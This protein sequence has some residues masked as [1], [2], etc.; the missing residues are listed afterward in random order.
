MES[1]KLKLLHWGEKQGLF[2]D[3][4]CIYVSR[5]VM[6]FSNCPLNMF[7]MLPLS[8]PP[9]SK[10]YKIIACCSPCRCCHQP[11]RPRDGRS[12]PQGDASACR[13][14]A[15]ATNS[16]AVIRVPLAT[17]AFSMP[18]AFARNSATLFHVARTSLKNF[19]SSLCVSWAF[20]CSFYCS[21]K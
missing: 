7:K 21:N 12:A 4:K 19:L 2:Q 17:A 8:L 3:I 14:P 13:N 15:L 20:L 18:I 10:R 1:I 16:L 11:C 6:V 9:A 5:T